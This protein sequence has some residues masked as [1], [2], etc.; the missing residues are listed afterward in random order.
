M[1][2]RGRPAPE[3]PLANGTC[4]RMYIAKLEKLSV[5]YQITAYLGGDIYAV[6]CV[7]TGVRTYCSRNDMR[8]IET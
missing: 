8:K 5:P 2:M 1:M 3:D 7:E 4:F 6:E